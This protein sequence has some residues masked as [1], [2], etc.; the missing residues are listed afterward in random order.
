M[1]KMCPRKDDSLAIAI[2]NLFQ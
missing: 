2:I 1:L